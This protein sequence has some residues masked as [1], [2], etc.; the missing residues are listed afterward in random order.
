MSETETTYS[1]CQRCGRIFTESADPLCAVCKEELQAGLG[2]AEKSA[3]GGLKVRVS[4]I[5][6]AARASQK[7]GEDFDEALLRALKAHY[8]ER[9]AHLLPALNK[10]VEFEANN[11]NENREQTLARLVEAEPGPEITFKSSTAGP[12]K[13][14]TEIIFNSKKYSSLDE[15]PPHLREMVQKAMRGQKTVVVRRAGCMSFLLGGWA[16]AIFRGLGK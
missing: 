12:I 9:A 15:V 4:P 10:L 6:K 3:G 1:K 11:A 16:I 14:S 8:P 2:A 7:P 5:I 13:A